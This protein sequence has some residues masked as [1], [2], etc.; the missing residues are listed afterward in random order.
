MNIFGT[1]RSPDGAVE[2]VEV[3]RE[4]YDEEAYRAVVSQVPEGWVLLH[5]RVDR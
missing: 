5:V 2:T 4:A 3:E 1:V